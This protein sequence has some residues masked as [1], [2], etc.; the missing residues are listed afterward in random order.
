[1][2]RLPRFP[3]LAMNPMVKVETMFIEFYALNYLGKVF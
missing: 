1:M 3:D 2:H